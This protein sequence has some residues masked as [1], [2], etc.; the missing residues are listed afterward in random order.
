MPSLGM[1]YGEG[2]P[3]PFAGRI[4]GLMKPGRFSGAEE[5]VKSLFLMLKKVSAAPLHLD[6]DEEAFGKG[7]SSTPTQLFPL[8]AG[9]RVQQGTEAGG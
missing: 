2:L 5:E 3:T 7:P 9:A 1:A 4:A 6:V 8:G